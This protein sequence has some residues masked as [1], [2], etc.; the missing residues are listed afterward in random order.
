MR[1]AD[2]TAGVAGRAGGLLPGKGFAI[3]L[4]L[5]DGGDAAVGAHVQSQSSLTSGLESVGAVCLS[6]AHQ[7][8]AGTE[9]LLGVRT[10]RHELLGNPGAVNAGPLSPLDQAARCPL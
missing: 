3:E 9:A 8:Q 10:V 1:P 6:Q 2:V 7:A 4:G 5:E